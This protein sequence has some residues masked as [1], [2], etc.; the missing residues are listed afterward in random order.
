MI[1]YVGE[2]LESYCNSPWTP[3]YHSKVNWKGSKAGVRATQSGGLE[4]KVD[5]Q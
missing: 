3:P 5:L 2:H 4:L 1:K